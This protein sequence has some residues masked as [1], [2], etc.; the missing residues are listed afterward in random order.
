MEVVKN[1][2]GEEFK[3]KVLKQV[4]ADKIEFQVERFTHLEYVVKSTERTEEM[5]QLLNI[6]RT[7][8]PENAST[9]S[10]FEKN[11]LQILLC[12]TDEKLAK[13]H[14]QLV[15]KKKYLQ[16]FTDTLLKQIEDC[17]NNAEEIFEKAFSFYVNNLSSKKNEK[18][19]AF[20]ESFAELEEKDIEANWEERLVFFIA[21]K[22]ILKS[23]K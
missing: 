16:E 22:R 14:K 10:E 12:E 15:E 4:T 13:L 6:R 5:I 23:E 7:L 9:K 20:A 19:I 17:N 1:H 18:V 8:A 21:L 3:Q 11:E 2:F